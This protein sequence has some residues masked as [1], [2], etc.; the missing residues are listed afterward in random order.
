M[1]YIWR[2]ST[3]QSTRLLS[4]FDKKPIHHG[5]CLW[6]VI[7]LAAS[8]DVN[9]YLH[10]LTEMICFTHIKLYLATAKSRPNR[11]NV[12][13]ENNSF[14]FS[15][16]HASGLLWSFSMGGNVLLCITSGIRIWEFWPFSHITT[17]IKSV[18]SKVYLLLRLMVRTVLWLLSVLQ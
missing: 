11:V 14:S 5:L 13:R 15:I 18:L 8:C 4:L 7:I 16:F 1:P 12:S 9:E 6:S 2:V 10:D 3:H 17:P